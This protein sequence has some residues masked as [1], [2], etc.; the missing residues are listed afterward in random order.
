MNHTD[1]RDEQDDR[2]LFICVRIEAANKRTLQEIE[3]EHT[4][5]CFEKGVYLQMLFSLP[6]RLHV[7]FSISPLAAK[8]VVCLFPR[9]LSGIF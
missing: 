5:L 6:C 1:N 4:Y 2:A 9:G 8:S 7:I 3:K